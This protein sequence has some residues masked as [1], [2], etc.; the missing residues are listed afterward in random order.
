VNLTS[1]PSLFLWQT[2]DGS[3]STF[4]R[5]G[6]PW[7]TIGIKCEDIHALRT[8]LLKAEVEIVVFQD[9]GCGMVLKCFDPFGNMLVIVE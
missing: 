8:A 6:K 3:V 7:P 1:G 5:D 9:D 4:T 2:G